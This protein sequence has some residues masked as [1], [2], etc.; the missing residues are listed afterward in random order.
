MGDLIDINEW[1]ET[2]VNK[3]AQRFRC[4]IDNKRGKELE[5]VL[6]EWGHKMATYKTHYART[7]REQ[8]K[9]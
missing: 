1:V 6:K 8:G 3:L 9:E 4:C 7:Q 5:C 2:K